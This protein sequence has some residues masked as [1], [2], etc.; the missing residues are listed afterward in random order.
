MQEFLQIILSL[1]TLLYTIL[2]GVALL[3]WLFVILGALDLDIFDLDGDLD[4]DV[5]VGGEGL[6]VDTHID[7]PSADAE[8]QGEVN[9]LVRLLG[10]LGWTGVPITIT[11]SVFFLFNWVLNYIGEWSLGQ[12]GPLA[13]VAVF[14]ASLVVSAPVTSLC[15]RPL[16]DMFRVKRRVGGDNLIGQTV[17]IM[18]SEVTDRMGNARL[19]DGAIRQELS[20]R[21]DV[22]NG[23][24]RGMEALIIGY[25]DE[26]H[27]YFVEPM[28]VVFMTT[29]ARRDAEPIEEDSP[30]R[31]QS[32]GSR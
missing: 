2:L 28:G 30:V 21:A 26:R 18:S 14:V 29:P 19:D 9:A 10:A 31:G 6:H 32:S 3:Y 15:V 16:R 20:V 22:P 13:E 7:A 8:A 17:K 27:V 1:P 24:A 4:V 12:Y 5:H 11:L 25:D 23:L